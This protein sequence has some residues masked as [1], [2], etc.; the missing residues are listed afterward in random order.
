M[1]IDLVQIGNF[2]IHGYGLM[3]ALGF[4]AAITYASFQAK[5]LGLNDDYVFNLA[6]F[7]LVFGWLGGK[8]LYCIVEYKQFFADPMSVLGSE[9]FVVYGGIISGIITMFIYTKIK[10]V[11]TLSYIDI[12]AAAVPINQ[13]LGRVG[14][15]LAGCCYGRETDSPIGVIF[16]SGCLAPAGVKLLPTQLFSAAFDLCLFIFLVIMINRK[17][18][19]GTIMATYLCGYA[20]GRFII[21]IFRNDNRGQVGVLSTSQFISIII[22][23][24]GVLMFVYLKRKPEPVNDCEQKDTDEKSVQE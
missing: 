24:L 12:I 19:K 3:I 20:V 9:G 21:E 13:S 7:V 22:L 11:D 23:A 16:P 2:T 14:C 8:A 18:K 5:K 15:F 4:L 1:A 10:R 17:H 6:M